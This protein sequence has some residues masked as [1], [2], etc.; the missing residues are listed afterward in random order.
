MIQEAEYVIVGIGAGMSVAAGAIYGGD[1]FKE[2]FA[3]FCAKYGN[4]SYMQDM[5]SAGFYPYPSEE[6]YW[7]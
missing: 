7:G 6:A 5:Y 2:N 4:G 1:W 3:D